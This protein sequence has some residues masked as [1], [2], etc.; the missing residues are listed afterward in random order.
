LIWCMTLHISWKN[1]RTCEE[2]PSI[3]KPSSCIGHFLWLPIQQLG[4]LFMVPGTL[5][6]WSCNFNLLCES[7]QVTLPVCTASSLHEKGYRQWLFS[8]AETIFFLILMKFYNKTSKLSKYNNG[9]HLVVQV[10]SGWL[11]PVNAC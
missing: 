11:G 2:S 8:A 9:L 7:G 4:Q 6:L 5:R 10:F 3:S 1:R